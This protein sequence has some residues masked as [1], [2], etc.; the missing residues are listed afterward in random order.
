MKN[1]FLILFITMSF[2]SLAQKWA[3]P[4]AKWEI[5][6]NSY[7]SPTIHRS[8]SGI[9]DTIITGVPCKKI[10]TFNP[11]FS[12]L[13]GDTVYF[14]LDGDFRPTYYYG[15][16]VG[17]TIVFYN[18]TQI[19]TPD[20]SL[21][22]AVIDSVK[23]IVLSGQ[24]LKMFYPTAIPNSTGQKIFPPIS[25]YIEKIGSNFI[26]PI[27][28]LNCVTDLPLYSICSYEDSITAKFILDPSACDKTSSSDFEGNSFVQLYPNPV[29]AHVNIKVTNA[30]L[31]G[32]ELIITDLLGRTVAKQTLLQELTNFNTQ[33]WANG[34]YVWSLVED[35]RTVR[36]GK[37]VKE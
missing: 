9:K 5:G 11:T 16:L 15:A 18:T 14:Y 13:S 27:F 30:Q 36:S 22:Y 33:D 28:N 3:A 1:L 7:P 32:V 6:V 19:C 2:C 4:G 20:D 25:P 17:D 23:S 10:G 24:I 29:I 12:Y 31:S 34:M 37:L 35:G 21:V 26:R 8:I